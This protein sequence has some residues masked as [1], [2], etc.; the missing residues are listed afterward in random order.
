MRKLA[1]LVIAV[2]VVTA[3][4]CVAAAEN[5]YAAIRGGPSHTPDSK[6]GIPGDREEQEYKLGFTGGGALGYS[7]PFG[8]RTEAEIGFLYT[9]VDKDGG[10]DVSGSYKTYLLMVNAYYDFKFPFFGPFKPYIG[11]GIGGARVNEDRQVFYETQGLKVPVD[12][13]RTALA[14]QGRAGIGYDVNKWLDLSVG[15]RFVRVNGSTEKIGCCG[16]KV[17]YDDVNNHSVELG[18]AVKF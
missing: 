6:E 4:P 12:E 9:P 2:A 5:F 3:F 13:W 1:W 10:R 15:Y 14:W 7:F 18:F 8:L 11:G 16:P 17:K